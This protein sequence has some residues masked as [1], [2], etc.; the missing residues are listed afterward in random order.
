VRHEHLLLPSVELTLAKVNGAKYF[1]K[2]DANS[3]SWQIQLAP[4]SSS[5]IKAYNIHYTFWMLCFQQ[6]TIWYNISTFSAQDE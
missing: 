4:E 2:L 6:T 3:G 5:L 1:S